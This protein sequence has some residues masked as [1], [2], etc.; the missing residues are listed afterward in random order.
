MTLLDYKGNS[1]NLQ[2]KGS[3]LRHKMYKLYLTSTLYI[4]SWHLC[5]ENKNLMLKRILCCSVSI[6]LKE[7]HCK[8]SSLC[9]DIFRI[10]LMKDD[11]LSCNSSTQMNYRKDMHHILTHKMDS[12]H[13][14]DM[15]LSHI[16]GKL[17]ENML[18]SWDPHIEYIDFPKENSYSY[19]YHIEN[20]NCRKHS[21]SGSSRRFGID[22]L[23]SQGKI[24]FSKTHK[25]RNS[26]NPGTRSEQ[27]DR[28]CSRL[29]EVAEGAEFAGGRRGA[30][31]AACES[32]CALN[33]DR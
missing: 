15:N 27:K 24:H 13:Y 14:P 17:T 30:L 20:L 21:R 33:A 11:D 2:L 8:F 19:S 25:S 5:K 28:E 29:Q 16:E 1:L 23:K 7:I 10:G 18:N 9:Q 31:F 12:F 3:I 6:E 32:S 4:H 26:S 22:L